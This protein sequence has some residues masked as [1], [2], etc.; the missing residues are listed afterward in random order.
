[1]KKSKLFFVLLVLLFGTI[2]LNNVSAI[3]FV[4]EE[5]IVDPDPDNPFQ[6][7]WILSILGSTYVHVINGMKGEWYAYTLS[8]REWVK[9]ASYTIIPKGDGFITN[10]KWNISVT[11]GKDGDILTVVKDKYKRYVLE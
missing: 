6:G 10:T 9:R 1:M 3:D 5:M 11:K 7:T 8:K 2:C 4:S